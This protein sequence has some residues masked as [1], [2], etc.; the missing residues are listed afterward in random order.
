MKFINFHHVY[1]IWSLLRVTLFCTQKTKSQYNSKCTSL[2]VWQ[3]VKLDCG[4]FVNYHLNL[5]KAK[6]YKSECT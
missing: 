4:V 5:F 6:K 3:Q 2:I 1:K